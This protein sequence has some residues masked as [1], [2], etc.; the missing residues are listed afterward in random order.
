MA[1][2]HKVV[3]RGDKMVSFVPAW[4]HGEYEIITHGNHNNFIIHPI[5]ADFISMDD[6]GTLYDFRCT[7]AYIK[8]YI[9]E[10]SDILL[11]K[12]EEYRNIIKNRE[13]NFSCRERK[14]KKTEVYNVLNPNNNRDLK[15]F[16]KWYLL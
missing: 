7:S 16:I 8:D 1:R 14:R 6:K 13:G 3:Y 2:Y 10:I 9:F 12:L 5:C 11:V 15:D 4:Y